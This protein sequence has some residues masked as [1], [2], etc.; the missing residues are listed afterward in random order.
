[1]KFASF[2]LLREVYDPD[3]IIRKD[4][5]WFENIP[6]STEIP[7]LEYLL[8]RIRAKCDMGRLDGRA[9]FR[10]HTADVIGQLPEAGVLRQLASDWC[11]R[12]SETYHLLLLDDPEKAQ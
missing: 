9:R 6:A 10:T 7:V 2:T 1:M 3:L 12:Q 8:K 11:R 4:P 5:K